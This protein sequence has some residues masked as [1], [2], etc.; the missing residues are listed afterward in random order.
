[1]TVIRGKVRPDGDFPKETFGYIA[2]RNSAH[3]WRTPLSDRSEV[4]KTV[5][6]CKKDE[7]TYRLRV[8]RYKLVEVTEI[9]CIGERP[10]G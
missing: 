3:N 5:E 4:D 7:K 9:E 2:D 1:M 10:N 6:V 8:A